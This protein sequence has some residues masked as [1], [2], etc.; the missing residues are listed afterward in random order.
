MPIEVRLEPH[1]N[2][3]SPLGPESGS[4]LRAEGLEEPVA[5]LVNGR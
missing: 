1:L 3:K 4:D 5:R 2:T